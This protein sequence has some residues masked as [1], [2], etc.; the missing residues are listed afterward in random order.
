MPQRQNTNSRR[1]GNRF[2]ALKWKLRP[3]SMNRVAS[4]RK[5]LASVRSLQPFARN[6]DTVLEIVSGLKNDAA[7]AQQLLAE[8]D[9]RLGSV[10]V[11]AEAKLTEHRDVTAQLDQI[12]NEKGGPRK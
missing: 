3:E 4:A 7:Q 1:L 5:S 6:T 9:Q 12:K 11:E 10:K 8:A 2:A